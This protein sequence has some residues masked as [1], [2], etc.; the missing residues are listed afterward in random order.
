VHAS[1][2]Q[3]SHPVCLNAAIWYTMAAACRTIVMVLSLTALQTTE[4][5]ASDA[6][7]AFGSSAESQS[8]KLAARFATG[9]K[10]GIQLLTDELS[11]AENTMRNAAM[12]I[13]TAG[14]LESMT[15]KHNKLPEIN[16]L[17]QL[18][19]GHDQAGYDGVQKGQDML[20]EMIKEAQENLD[21][22]RQRCYTFI[23]SQSHQIWI[24]IQSIRMFDA[25]AAEARENVLAAQTE[26]ERLTNLLPKL[27]STLVS[28][29]RKCAVDV[30]ELEAQ[31]KIILGDIEVMTNVLKLTEC[32]TSLLMMHAT[33]INTLDTHQ[34]IQEGLDEACGDEIPAEEPHWS[35]SRGGMSLVQVSTNP[36]QM[37]KAKQ[38]SK[39]TLSKKSCKRLRDKFLMI[40]SGIEAKRDELMAELSALQRHCADEKANLESQ[41]SDAETDLKS[42]QTAL[43]KATKEQND[44]ERNSKLKNQERVQLI[45]ELIRMMRLCKVNINNF[46]SEGCALGKIRGQLEQMKGHTNPAFLQDCEVTD[47]SPEECSVSCG[48]GTQKLTRA[49]SVHPVGGAVCPPLEMTRK[50]NEDDCPIDCVVGDWSEWGDCSADCNAGVKQKIRNVLTIPQFGGVACGETSVAESCNMQSCDRDCIL[51]DWAPWSACSKECDGGL[52][53]RTKTVVEDLV[54]DG[55]CAEKDSDKRLEYMP[56]NEQ[57]CKG[58]VTCESMIDVVLLLDGSGSLGENGWEQTKKAA[59]MFVSALHG[60]KD[61]VMLSVI[62]FSGP[63][64]WSQYY[65]CTG[66]GSGAPPDLKEDCG[67]D[68]VQHLT[69]DMTATGSKIGALKWPAKSTLTSQA[70][71]IAQTELSLGR[72][73]AN[74]VVIVFTDGRP[75]NT[76][77]TKSVAKEL[78]ETSRLMWVPVGRNVPLELVK[79]WASTPKQD[80]VISVSEF[81]ALSD[82]ET[83][84]TIIADMCPKL[85]VCTADVFECP[86]GSSV[87]RDP[88][89]SCA[90]RECPR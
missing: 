16:A 86:D 63:R 39:C 61:N 81:E 64:T 68:I 74:S 13:T 2:S 35:E 26:I 88:K 82:P 50:C 6:D 30:A 70:L 29:N 80:N 87:G 9:E 25:R 31:L 51:S 67:I 47:W 22:E 54:G 44:A 53:A 79:E 69:T 15:K 77:R 37:D 72:K 62:L 42:W 45:K 36:T 89:N 57:K 19:F 65:S 41:I 56:C 20:N 34:L 71:K 33:R 27:T 40:Q 5:Q 24:T 84:S 7:T 43:A 8:A 23:K 55:K 10:E 17:I 14:A 1:A 59:Q 46:I 18:K 85:G 75:L 73:L 32:S 21:L 52:L 3:S 38:R 58:N 76:G 11:S 28:H 49:V 90:F 4:V 12:K 66:T 60:G 83:M 48:G 78:R